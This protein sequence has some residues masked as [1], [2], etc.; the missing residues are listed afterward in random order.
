[1][2]AFLDTNI[3]IYAAGAEHPL[4][5]PC[6]ELLRRVAVG[7]LDATT[8]AEVIQEIHHVYRKR[9]RLVEGVELGRQVLLLVPQLL[10]ITRAEVQRAGEILLK[11]QQLS[12]RDALHAATALN[13]GISAVLSVDR[14]FELIEGIQ[15]INPG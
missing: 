8:S 5:A 14:D 4:K 3:F 13:N 11:H 9:G 10:P 7:D 1:M 12:P 6:V 2:V 15:R